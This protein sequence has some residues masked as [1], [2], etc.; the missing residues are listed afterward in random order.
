[1]PKIP[2]IDTAP[3]LVVVGGHVAGLQ[4]RVEKRETAGITVHA[5]PVLI[6]PAGTEGMGITNEHLTSRRQGGAGSG[7]TM[8]RRRVGH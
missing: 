3:H 4:I 2:K 7:C 6:P 1:M 5:L 8:Q